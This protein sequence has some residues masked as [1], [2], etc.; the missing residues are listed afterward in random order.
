MSDESD[1]SGDSTSQE[2]RYRE[3]ELQL[4]DE[5]D[6]MDVPSPFALTPAIAMQGI[7]NYQTN[8]GH[9]MYSGSIAK[10]DEELYDCKPKGLYQFLQSLSSG[11]QDI[12]WSDDDGILMIPEDPRDI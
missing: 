11:A 7:I 12:G 8:S 1:A 3:E 9:K 4:Q 5:W 6:D 2:C 10:L